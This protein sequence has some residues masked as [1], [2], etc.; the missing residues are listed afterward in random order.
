[1]DQI[2]RVQTTLWLKFEIGHQIF[3]PFIFGPDDIQIRSKI[4]L[5]AKM[6][7]KI[8]RNFTNRPTWP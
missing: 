4:E 8:L 5:V 1:M 7:K 2:E 6:R 3:Q